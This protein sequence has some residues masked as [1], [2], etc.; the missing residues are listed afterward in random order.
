[1]ACTYKGSLN[2]FLLTAIRGDEA[3]AD[4]NRAVTNFFQKCVENVNKKCALTDGSYTAKDLQDKWDQWLDILYQRPTR[5][6][7]KDGKTVTIPKYQEWRSAKEEMNNNLFEGPGDAAW[8]LYAEKLYKA[9]KDAKIDIKGPTTKKM[10]REQT[11]ANQI[12]YQSSKD[13][14]AANRQILQA[15]TCGD[16]VNPDGYTASEKDFKTTLKAWKDRSTYMYD[17]YIKTQLTCY[18]WQTPAKERY[19]PRSG[20]TITSADI[21]FVQTL[22]DPVTPEIS[23]TN[24]MNTFANAGI[25]KHTGVGVSSPQSWRFISNFTQHCSNRDSSDDLDSKVKQYWSSGKVPAQAKP[26]TPNVPNPFD[27]DVPKNDQTDTVDQ[28]GGN[29]AD[30]GSDTAS[31]K[32]RGVWWEFPRHLLEKPLETSQL[33][34]RQI[35]QIFVGCKPVGATTT[36]SSSTSSSTMSSTT[37]SESSTTTTQTTSS[38]SSSSTSTTTA[39]STTT[40]TSSTST[41]SDSSTSTVST[42]PSSTITS[43][44]S[45]SISSTSGSTTSGSFTSTSTS[46]GTGTVSTSTTKTSTST[47]GS[48]GTTGSTTTTSGSTSISTTGTASASTTT[49][50]LTTGTGSTTYT[51]TYTTGTYTLTS[52]TYTLTTSNSQTTS[53]SKSW[54]TQTRSSSYTSKPTWAT[55]D[56]WL[57]WSSTT[58]RASTKPSWA[59]GDEWSDWGVATTTTKPD[60]TAAWGNW[61]TGSDY[62]TFTK[63]STIVSTISK[64]PPQITG[65]KDVVSSRTVTITTVYPTITI[66]KTDVVEL[67]S[68][69]L[70]SKPITITETCKDGCSAR[71]TGAPPGYTVTKVWCDACATPA[72]VEVTSTVYVYGGDGNSASTKAPAAATP[73]SWD[74]WNSNGATTK[75]PAAATP[76]S[77][78]WGDWNGAGSNGATKTPDAASPS[79]SS[80]NTWDAAGSSA[81]KTP[82]AATGVKTYTG[83]ATKQV[84]SVS[85]LLAG[86]VAVMLL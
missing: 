23:A 28:V 64:C 43:T 52:G 12:T 18:G 67:C 73:V 41:T 69:G 62:K 4:T 76:A 40:G 15:V 6:D 51:Y 42:T 78:T 24:S 2:N 57:D 74:G 79:S 14:A 20:K 8:V 21:L 85:T 38:T 5:D 17:N 63:T 77:G 61:N 49:N 37:T 83:A 35:P 26:D 71:P 75:P 16:Y 19:Y 27:Y 59:T 47:T 33:S 13:A 58:T 32:K 84:I 82:A 68:T 81:S 31:V 65:C 7:V 10:K 46:T 34:R 53:S 22:Y 66:Y 44:S 45:T 70:T 50:T 30:D 11:A 86:L 3:A 55:G 80:W 1:M 36:S 29:G 54:T 56:E 48:P 72:F 39:S 25:L 60:P 9:F